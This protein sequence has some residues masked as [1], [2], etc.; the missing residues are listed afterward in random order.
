[1]KSI[2]FH[3]DFSSFTLSKLN[4]DEIGQIKKDGKDQSDTFHSPTNSEK[5]ENATFNIKSS[6]TLASKKSKYS[7]RSKLTKSKL[8]TALNKSKVH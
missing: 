6:I 5:L 1:M 7:T 3:F 4:M 8:F 2:K